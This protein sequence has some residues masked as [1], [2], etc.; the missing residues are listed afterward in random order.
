MAVRSLPRR[1]QYRLKPEI[2]DQCPAGSEPDLPLPRHWG[3][4][5]GAGDVGLGQRNKGLYR[6]LKV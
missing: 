5:G 4:G 2:S 3:G 1:S 6:E